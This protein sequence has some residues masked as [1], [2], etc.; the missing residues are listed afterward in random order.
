MLLEP[1]PITPTALHHSG[2][3]TRRTPFAVL[4]GTTRALYGKDL[5]VSP[6]LMTGNTD[7]RFYWDL[8]ENIFR[9]GPGWDKEQVGLGNIHTVDEKVGVQAHLDT[10]RW[11]VGWIRNM[12]EA[13]L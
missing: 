5:I 9:Y 3:H 12:D 11:M 6:G 8:T 1:A 2:N 7:T 4:A 13:V 10:V